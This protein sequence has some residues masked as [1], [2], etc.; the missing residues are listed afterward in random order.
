MRDTF[1]QMGARAHAFAVH[2][3]I[4]NKQE[5]KGKRRDNFEN[6]RRSS[7]F[8]CGR[9]QPAYAGAAE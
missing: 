7:R 2:E 6:A 1:A 5:T 4:D 3:A 9:D 8:G